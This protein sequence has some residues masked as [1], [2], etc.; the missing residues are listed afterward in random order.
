MVKS[1]RVGI[2]GLGTIGTKVAQALDSEALPG[3]SLHAVSGRDAERTRLTAEKLTS[4]PRAVATE[5]LATHAEIVVDC[6]PSGTFAS[7]A[8]SVVD[9][10]GTLVTVNAGALLRN[11]ELVEIAKQTG[12][13]IIVPTGALL[14]L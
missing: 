3:L 9:A 11:L 13:R 2:A 7:L 6:A 12:G 5:Q 1:L 14:G 10:G 8:R 4:R